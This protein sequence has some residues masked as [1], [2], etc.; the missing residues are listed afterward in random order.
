V[1]FELAVAASNVDSVL[2]MFCLNRLLD[3]EPAEDDGSCPF[4]ALPDKSLV[5]S[6]PAWIALLSDATPA[7]ECFEVPQELLA[8]DL[9]TLLKFCTDGTFEISFSSYSEL[10]P[11]VF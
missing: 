4:L 9:P 6:L 8:E 11:I 3:S 1:A 2:A 5:A 10:F 7:N